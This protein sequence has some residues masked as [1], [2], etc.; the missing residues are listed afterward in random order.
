MTTQNMT[1]LKNSKGDKTQKPNLEF[2][3]TQKHKMWQNTKTQNVTKFH[4]SKCD[5]T[6]T[7]IVT[8]LLNSKC[9]K[10]KK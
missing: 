9:E 5:E 1:K 3:K 10:L 8:K 2:K 4:D 6:E 7:E